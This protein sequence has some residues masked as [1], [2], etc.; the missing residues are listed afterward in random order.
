MVKSQKDKLPRL[1][2]LLLVVA[3]TVYIF[4]LPEEQIERLESFGYA[5][6]F[7]LSILGNATILL[8]AP[9]LIFVFTMGARFNPIGVALAA[10]TG[11]AIGELSGY[12]AGYS[13]QVVVKDSQTYDR[14]VDWMDRH[15]NWTV[16]TLAF[17]PNPFFDLAGVA[18]GVLKMRLWEF[19]LFA[20]IGKVLKTLVTAYAGAGVFSIP[21]LNN[22][23]IPQ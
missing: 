12:L 16:L 23:F 2:A 20:W 11:A 21:W 10:G 17:I 15:G 7:I 6:S 1:V 8:P 3:V 14:L 4:Y 9:W 19:L 22:F 18:A 5:G 13:G